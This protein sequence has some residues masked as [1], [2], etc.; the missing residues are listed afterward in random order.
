MVNKCI[1]IQSHFLLYLFYYLGNC[2]YP[3][4]FDILIGHHSSLYNLCSTSSEAQNH[5]NSVTLQNQN[6]KEK[7]NKNQFELEP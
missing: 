2:S 6:S 7:K 1:S 3:K 5:E 4:F